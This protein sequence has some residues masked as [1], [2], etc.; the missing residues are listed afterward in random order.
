MSDVGRDAGIRTEK[1]GKTADA[2]STG[3]T[4]KYRKT[5]GI[6]PLESDYSWSLL[7]RFS[8]VS[9]DTKRTQ[10]FDP[11]RSPKRAVA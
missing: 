6:A 10:G 2:F 9:T 8:E 7:E 1:G 5:E 4:S 11:Q 3:D